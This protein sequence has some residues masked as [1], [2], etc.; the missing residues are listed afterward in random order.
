MPK[1]TILESYVSTMTESR[2]GE[3]DMSQGQKKQLRLGDGS[4]VLVDWKSAELIRKAY[5]ADAN[6]QRFEDLLFASTR[7]YFN[8]VDWSFRLALGH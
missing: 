8:M 3:F 4:S 2:M 5:D 7:S 6:K 1:D